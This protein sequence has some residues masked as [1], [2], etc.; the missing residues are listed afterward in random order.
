MHTRGA[1]SVKQ[2]LSHFFLPNAWQCFWNCDRCNV[3][4][5][6]SFQGC[7]FWLE[8][9]FC[10]NILTSLLKKYYSVVDINDKE[11]KLFIEFVTQSINQS[12]KIFKTF[13]VCKWLDLNGRK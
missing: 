2:A 9:L 6:L 4:W 8:P 1:D 13:F 7:V 10:I 11:H 12:I 5:L 3:S